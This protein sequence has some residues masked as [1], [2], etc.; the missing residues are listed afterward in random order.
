MGV[1]FTMLST[2]WARRG[3][4]RVHGHTV[5]FCSRVGRVEQ[6]ARGLRL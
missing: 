2:V 1:L 4:E 6:G 3:E 5:R